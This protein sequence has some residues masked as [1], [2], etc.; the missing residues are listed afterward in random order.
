LLKQDTNNTPSTIPPALSKHVD[1]GRNR[2][3]NGN[4]LFIEGEQRSKAAKRFRDIV[5]AV[6]AD[7]GGADRLSEG[8]KQLVGRCSLISVECERMEA[9]SVAG[10]DIDLE[11]F[12]TLTDRLGRTLARLGL[13]RVPKVVETPS[14]EQYLAAKY[15]AKDE[16]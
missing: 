11:L 13:R 10:E 14:L 2:V 5:S 4:A 16:E 6:T 15:S 1:K 8:Q 12:G 7:L 9:R 3:T